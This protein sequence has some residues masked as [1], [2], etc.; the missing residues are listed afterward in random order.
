[1]LDVATI[2]AGSLESIEMIHVYFGGTWLPKMREEMFHGGAQKWGHLEFLSP[3]PPSPP[4]PHPA[5]LLPS[6]STDPSSCHSGCIGGV[7]T[8]HAT[9]YCVNCRQAGVHASI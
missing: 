5:T 8:V 3:P 1:M 4:P 2:L 6:V 7:H 9:C